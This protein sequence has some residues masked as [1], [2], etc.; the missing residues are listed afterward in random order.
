MNATHWRWDEYS[1]K[2]S[3]HA[4]GWASTDRGWLFAGRGERARTLG[5]YLDYGPC[6]PHYAAD[7]D[8]CTVHA[9]SCMRPSETGYGYASAW[10]ATVAAAKAWIE[11]HA[12]DS[13]SP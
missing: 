9:V 13:S 2:L 5:H 1:D 12:Q 4:D 8:G 3:F 6:G 7:N 10:C 11:A